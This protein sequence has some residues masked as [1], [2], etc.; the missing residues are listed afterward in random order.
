LIDGNRLSAMAARNNSARLFLVIAG[1]VAMAWAL[2]VVPVFWSENVIADVARAMIAGEAFKTEIL[3]AVE[4]RTETNSGS[5]LRSSLLGKAAVIRLRQTEDAIRAGDPEFIDQRLESLARI[6]DETFLNAPSDPF[7]W[8]VRFWLDVTRNGLRSENLRFLRMSYDLGPY[9][10]WIAVKRNRMALA[11]FS[12]LPGDLA[13]L[14]ISEFVGLVRW[15]L[16]SEAAEIA[17]GPARPLR[18]ILFPRLKDLKY[19]QRRSFAG[20]I[21]QRDLDDVLVPG[22]NPPSGQIP[23]PVLPP[24]F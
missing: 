2:T 15:G 19:E 9:E 5:M 16:L 14:A 13:E 18:G 24:G 7:L 17:A 12:A 21:Y 23:M 3:A 22:V 4:A 11:A 1:A 10:G 20:L 6:V 8:L